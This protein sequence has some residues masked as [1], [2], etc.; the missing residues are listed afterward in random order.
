MRR[1]WGDRPS[2]DDY[3]GKFPSLSLTLGEAIPP[4]TGGELP[5]VPGYEMLGELG[6]GGMG[7]V[8]KARQAR[9][10]PP[11]RP[12]DD[13]AP[14]R[15]PPTRG[16]ARFRAEAEAVA[17]LHIPNIVQIH[18][19]GEHDGRPYFAL[20][21]V[22]GGSLAGK[23][24]GTPLAAAA[25]RPRLVETLARA[26]HA[27]HQGGVV[28]RDLKPANILLTADGAPKITDFGLAKAAGARRRP[29]ADRGGHGH[30]ELHGPR[31]GGGPSKGVGPACDVYAL[32]RSS[33][34]R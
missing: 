34:K 16:C 14:A 6:R 25:R 17:R 10:Q 2:A 19:V 23:L 32:G 22:D 29:D 31:A 15:T 13:P 21:F 1:C 30:A 7:V 27:A 11:R 3:R 18:E 24:G 8:Y 26:V 5:A 33:T 4:P 20:E 12:Q 28:H 9:P